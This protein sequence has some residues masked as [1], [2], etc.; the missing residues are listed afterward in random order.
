MNMNC[1]IVQR[2]AFTRMWCRCLRAAARAAG[3]WGVSVPTASAETAQRCPG[4]QP[5]AC[6]RHPR[7]DQATAAAAGSEH[8][9][10]VECHEWRE[11]LKEPCLTSDHLH[12]LHDFEISYAGN[13]VLHYLLFHF[14]LLWLS[15]KVSEFWPQTWCG[16][17]CGAVRSAQPARW[18][19]PTGQ[20]RS[21]GASALGGAGDQ[22][23]QSLFGEDNICSQ[24][25]APLCAVLLSGWIFW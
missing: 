7:N 14:I 20:R 5:A 21:A 13:E 24:S 15:D 23:P 1:D 6:C 22:Y 11:I 25:Y 10:Q 4:S 2:G 18:M 12:F 9:R 19:S 16:L 3:G 8:R 17:R